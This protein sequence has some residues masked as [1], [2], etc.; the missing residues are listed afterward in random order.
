MTSSIW[1]V[2]AAVT[3]AICVAGAALAACGPSKDDGGGGCKTALLPGD[4]VISE[5]FADY[6]APSGGT[7][8]DTGKEWF[9][10]YNARSEPAALG[11]LTITH[12][13][14]DGTKP[15]LHVMASVMIAPG[16]YF[17]L[18]NAAQEFV[19]AYIDYGY[20][21]DLGDLF[22][23]DGGKLA[24]SCGDTEIDSA[25]YDSVHEGH[26]RELS[27]A[28]LPDYTANDRQAGWCEATASEFEAG[29]FGTPGQQND[30]QPVVS[31]QCDDGGAMRDAVTPGPG[32]LVITEVMPNPAKAGDATGEWFE[33]KVM[34]DVDLN[35]VGLDRVGDTAKPDV[36]S[37][38]RCLAARAGS[39]VVFAKSTDMATNGG[40]DPSVIVGTFKFSMVTGSAAAPGD[41]AIVAGTT[42]VDA[43]R[44]T[45]S[46]NGKA[47]QLDPDLT[48]PTANDTE[49]NFCDA[50][51][52]YGLGDLGTPGL[53]NSQCG[54][55]PGAGMCDDNGRMRPI[56]A[57]AA[58]KLVISEVLANP[59]PY[60][61]PDDPSKTLNDDAHREWFEVTN[62]GATAFD[63]NDLQVGRIGAT[64]AP[65]QSATCLSVAAGKAAVFARSNDP[66][67]NGKL[68]RVDATFSFALVDSNGDVQIARGADVLDAASWKSVGSGLTRQLDPAHLT[69]DENDDKA[70]DRTHFCAGATAYG[71]G[72]NKGTP[73]AANAPCP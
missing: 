5:V 27:A 41:V 28:Q 17:T 40:I 73:G 48:D 11:G 68:P 58:G 45:G 4:L 30:C 51:A 16:Q 66:A 69:T 22:N 47:L 35:G 49:S 9:E 39:Y 38:A 57:P 50:T 65:V 14:P 70:G 6:K 59:A 55:L 36:I 8:A 15:N 2:T 18:A 19:P 44:W 52:P 23:S 43:V 13:R 62:V 32:D 31:G 24:L 54:A 7:G 10:I 67:L 37:G 12:S 29:N 3:R 33:A 46:S 72:T 56:V 42:T 53:A 25:V 20:G 1:D 21:P 63:L 64:G 26:A 61:D 60:P 34:R 71:D